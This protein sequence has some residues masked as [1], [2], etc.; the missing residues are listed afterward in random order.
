MPYPTW[1]TLD[2]EQSTGLEPAASCLEWQALYQL[3]YDCKQKEPP[4]R[5]LSRH[6]QRLSTPL[7]LIKHLFACG[8]FLFCFVQ[9][10]AVIPAAIIGICALYAVIYPTAHGAF[11]KIIVLFKVMLPTQRANGFVIHRF[12]FPQPQV[13][14]YNTLPHHRACACLDRSRPA[15]GPVVQ[16]I[17]PRSCGMGRTPARR[18]PLGQESVLG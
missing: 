14:V 17:L 15:S 8:K 4:Q 12:L 16:D 7:L 11:L 1:P 13:G 5:T 2:M 9:A 18:G 10:D 3:S 6:L